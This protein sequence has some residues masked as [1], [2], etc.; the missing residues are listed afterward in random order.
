MRAN[1]HRTTRA[2]LGTTI[3]LDPANVW[4]IGWV[5]IGLL[6]L[7]AVLQFVLGRG[8]ALIFTVVMAWFASLAIE[9]LVSRLATRMRRGAATGGP[10]RCSRRRASPPGGRPRRPWSRRGPA[11]ASGTPR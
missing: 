9:P 4:R 5:V 3:R 8:S 1:E 7:V 6:A 11:P 10:V 2:D